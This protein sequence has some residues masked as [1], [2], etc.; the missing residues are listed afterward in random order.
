MKENTRLGDRLRAARIAARI[1]Q[2]DLARGAGISASFLSQLERG[3]K[4]PGLKVARRLAAVLG[5][6]IER[7]FY[8]SK[9]RQ[10]GARVGGSPGAA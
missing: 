3:L 6:S 9:G 4:A 1:K 7:L 8:G 2:E 10:G 5:V